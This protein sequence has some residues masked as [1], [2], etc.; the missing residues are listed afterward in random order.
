MGLA[1]PVHDAV[2][3]LLR[4]PVGAEIVRGGIGR[5]RQR[6]RGTNRIVHRHPPR[7]GVVA[8]GHVVGV[9]A[10]VDHRRRQAVLIERFGIE[11]DPVRLL[12][13]VLAHDPHA[14]HVLVAIHGRGELPAP[15]T[16][17][18][19]GGHEGQPER[20]GLQLV[21][22]DEAARGVVM[23][24]V[25]HDPRHRR[26]APHPHGPVEDPVDRTG[27]VTHVVASD[28]SRGV[29]QP[30]REHRGGRVQKE[31]R[32]LDGVARDADDAGG[33]TL[34]DTI[35]VEVDH[36]GDLAVGTVLDP[37]HMA[38]LA[39]LK[40]AGLFA[41]GDFGV[42]GGPLGPPLA[43]LKA[44]AGLL[45]GHAI[46]VF[47][48]VDRHPTG[49]D[50]LVA[51]RLC[52]LL[53]DEVIVVPRQARAPAR[54]GH[55]HLG[56]GLL[57]PGCHLG[58]VD[59][60]VEQ[61]RALDCAVG[62]QGF[63]LM[64]L[65]PDRGPGPMRGGA[66]HGLDD[67]RRQAAEVAGHPPVARRLAGVRPGELREAV[68]LV[69]DIVLGKVAPAGLEG[70]DGNALLRQLVGERAAARAGADDNDHAVVALVEWSCHVRSPPQSQAMSL[71]PRSM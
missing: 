35:R 33:L 1:P 7:I 51:D 6:P 18:E 9:V 36:S 47:Q 32:A 4:H 17:V 22:A 27:D 65:E 48:R 52:A 21:A 53:E 38:A 64:V 45:A 61:V 29:R 40:V 54:A 58:S 14:G 24:L 42:G 43:A 15:G 25:L 12:R 39:H 3:G 56:L 70:H 63:P 13:H 66:A 34:L 50:L 20:E 8:H 16:G 23:R 60:P 5:R 55:A 71:K 37:R 59:R 28:L 62:L 31:P 57:V 30:V 41:R 67:P 11:G 26:P 44:E 49:M 46:T 69:V 68:P 10:V 2:S 19:E